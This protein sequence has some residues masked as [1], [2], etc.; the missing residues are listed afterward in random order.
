MNRRNF[1]HT[2]I[3]SS[4]FALIPKVRGAMNNELCI[5]AIGVGGK[6]RSDLDQLARH[7]KVVAVCDVNSHKLNFA[8]KSYTSATKYSDYRKMIAQWAGKID[9][10]SISSPDHTHAHATQLALKAGMQVFVQ[11]P[12]AHTVWEARQLRILA[13]ELNACVQVGMQGCAHDGFRLA[14]EYLQAGGIGDVSE[15][16]V[17]T[18][19]PTWPQ[20]PIITARPEGKTPVPKEINWDGFIGPSLFRDY[21]PCYQPYKWRGWRDFGSGAIG[22]SG[23]HLLNLPVMGCGLRSPEK[24][25]CLLR[26]PFHQETFPGWGTVRFDFS[27]SKGKTALFWYEGKVSHLSAQAKGTPNIPSSDLFLGKKPTPQGCIIVG[28]KGTLFSSSHFGTSWEVNLGKKWL[29]PH[30]LSLPPKSLKRNGRGDSG[31][32][33]ELVLAIREGNPLLPFANFDYAA[34]LN[35]WI[36]LGNVA[37]AKGGEFRWDEKRFSTGRTDTNA[38][39]T[40]SYRKGWAVKPV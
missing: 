7:G 28:S 3:S 4:A 30:E 38:L 34:K 16:H 18:N 23:M 9:I 27:S 35:E 36:L 32:K 20:G 6:G 11:T 26:A 17:W 40:K 39:L 19:Q 24:V 22:D 21:H 8:Q 10:I 2:A 37:M 33:E 14:V 1:V 31:M 29:M 25:T 12:M 15:I 5:G 13:K